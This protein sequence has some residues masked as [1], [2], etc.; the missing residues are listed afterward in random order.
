MPLGDTFLAVVHDA[1]DEFAGELRAEAGVGSQVRLA[2]SELT[3][4]EN[5]SWK[6]VVMVRESLVRV[7]TAEQSRSAADLCSGSPL[8]L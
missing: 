2:G 4:H 6:I 5:R 7:I 3:G 8:K 1:V